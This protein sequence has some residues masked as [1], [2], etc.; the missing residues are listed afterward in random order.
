MRDRV[1]YIARQGPWCHGPPV[2]KGFVICQRP[3]YVLSQAI[4][5]KV[6]RRNRGI[7]AQCLCERTPSPPLVNRENIKKQKT[8]TSIAKHPSH[9]VGR[10]EGSMARDGDAFDNRFKILL[11]GDRFVSIAPTTRLPC[12]PPCLRGACPF[13]VYKPRALAFLWGARHGREGEQG[14]ED[15]SGNLKAM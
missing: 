1:R 13:V 6:D 15:D 3:P 12:A 10:V 5:L 4:L 2:E 9:W 7:E 8:T 14:F 11:T